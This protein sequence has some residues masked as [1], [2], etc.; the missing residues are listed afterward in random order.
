M[1]LGFY[2]RSFTLADSSCNTAGC[3]WTA[4]GTAGP[5]TGNVGTLSFSEIKAQLKRGADVSLDTTAA[6]EEVTFAPSQWVS[7][8]D[9]QTFSMKFDYANTHCVGGLLV[10]AASLDDRN[11]TAQKEL[12]QSLGCTVRVPSGVA[13]PYSCGSSS[14]CKEWH[15][16]VEGDTCYAL[17][18]GAHLT[19]PGLRAL[20]P[21]L[22]A[23]CSNL[24]LGYQYCVA[25]VPTGNSTATVGSLG[26]GTL[27]P[28][29]SSSPSS[30]PNAVP[31]GGKGS[32]GASTPLFTLT[33]SSAAP[34]EGTGVPSNCVVTTRLV[35]MRKAEL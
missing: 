34:S 11:G 22:N 3:L 8:D 24:D 15:T 10:W 31:S 9:A 32:G 7:Y 16:V 1:G 29:C 33:P 2:G 5:C 6:V 18:T 12:C 19:L 4:G 14:K 27:G 26:G 35:P 30:K 20:N 28:G 13:A 23:A 21:Q 17:Y 25:G